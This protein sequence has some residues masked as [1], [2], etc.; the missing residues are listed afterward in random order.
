MTVEVHV[1]ASG[2][3]GNCTVVK[4]DDRAVV[5]DAGLSGKKLMSLMDL[6]GLDSSCID[7]ILITHEHSDHISG[8]GVL[9]RKL[10]IPVMCN[11]RTFDACNLGNVK[12][13]PISMMNPF[14]VA[15]MNAIALPTSHDA[16]EPS[17]YLLDAGGFKVLVATDTGMITY[18][19]EHA[20][21]EA[22]IAVIESNYD[23]KMLDEGPYPLSL[24]RHIDSNTG[25]LCNVATGEV[26]KRTMD[27]NPHRKIFLAHLSRHNN[28]PD[29][30]RETVSRITGI[31]RFQIDCLEYKGDTRIMHD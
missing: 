19:I 3:D 10:D 29:I 22:D 8:A 6:N 20:L 31:K 11:R 1:L 2:S 5:V 26:L 4:Y 24:K 25:H 16:A 14:E 7:S 15:G 27:I 28:E 17:S 9:A 23:K 30:A 13:D 12:Y 18:P 21:G